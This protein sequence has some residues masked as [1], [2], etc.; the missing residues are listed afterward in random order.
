MLG[1]TPASLSAVSAYTPSE[2]SNHGARWAGTPPTRITTLRVV[3]RDLRLGEVEHLKHDLRQTR[4]DEAG[5]REPEQPRVDPAQ[6][7]LGLVPR[8]M[9]E[10]AVE[11]HPHRARLVGDQRGDG[12]HVVE[13]RRQEL[14]GDE[15]A[16]ELVVD[17]GG[18]RAHSPAHVLVEEGLRTEVEH[19]L[20][21][22]RA[23]T[24]REVGADRDGRRYVRARHASVGRR[25]IARA[26]HGTPRRRQS[27]MSSALHAAWRRARRGP[28][29]SRITAGSSG[30]LARSRTRSSRT[31]APTPALRATAGRSPPPEACS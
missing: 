4:R 26:S 7:L 19:A 24:E 23:L 13:T 12:D 17:L 14:L 10:V 29:S 20:G 8:S 11:R 30:P 31:C 25:G 15:G 2:T 22:E 27:S 3:D 9:D 1:V 18:E 5:A 16:E 28:G 6:I 21:S